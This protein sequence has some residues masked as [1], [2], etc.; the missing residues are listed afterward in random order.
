MPKNP[1]KP[2][3]KE[4]PYVRIDARTLR[5]TGRTVSLSLRVTPAFDR[6]IREIAQAEGLLLAEVLE[7]AVKA[8]QDQSKK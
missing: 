7:R 4:I 8:L 2:I 6:A 5:K 1:A 3:T